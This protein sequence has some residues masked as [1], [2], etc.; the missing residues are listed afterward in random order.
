M[1]LICAGIAPL[2]QILVGPAG[3]M[4]AV[5]AGHSYEHRPVAID[6][7]NYLWVGRRID[8]PEER[9]GLDI[10]MMHPIVVGL[11]PAILIIIIRQDTP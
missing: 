1:T 6:R 4:V 2:L 3:Y 11:E 7:R 8:G 5:P 10:P 9:L